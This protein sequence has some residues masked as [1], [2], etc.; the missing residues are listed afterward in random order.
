MVSIVGVVVLALAAMDNMSA[1]A[2]L[3]SAWHASLRRFAVDHPVWLGSMHVATHLGDTI[4]V[5]LI[6]VTLI[7]VCVLGGRRGLAVF[8]A[9]VGV[10]GWA[11]RVGIRD[12]V[13]RPRPADAL[14]PETGFSFP[15]G[16]AANSA[17]AAGLAVIVLWPMSRR[18]ARAAL[19]FTALA[20]ALVV[21]LSRVA[22]GVHWPSDVVAG[23]LLA[24]SVLLAASATYVPRTGNA[25]TPENRRPPGTASDSAACP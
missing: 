21:G 11:A 1:V 5:T 14:W 9:I 6:D 24:A 7:V 8:V 3:D 23:L 13:D 20:Y 16:H 25:S 4:T 2:H 18:L 10:A 12:L 17:I 19:L 15:S 22:G